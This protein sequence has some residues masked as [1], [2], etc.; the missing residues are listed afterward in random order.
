MRSINY[1]N[2]R[3]LYVTAKRYG[4]VG[5]NKLYVSTK[6]TKWSKNGDYAYRMMTKTTINWYISAPI[7]PLYFLYYLLS[8]VLVAL[9]LIL[10]FKFNMLF[11]KATYTEDNGVY[12]SFMS[13]LEDCIHPDYSS[14]F[15][16]VRSDKMLD[17]KE[18]VKQAKLVWE[19]RK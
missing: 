15:D 19:K 3:Y 9:I 12:D 1:R 2:E 10:G 5:K 14:C 8:C 6:P 16:Y 17:D 13:A 7:I 18:L 11:K 4:L